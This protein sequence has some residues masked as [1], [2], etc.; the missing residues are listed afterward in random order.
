MSTA[1]PKKTCKYGSEIKSDERRET[2]AAH[3][4]NKYL[5]YFGALKFIL[6]VHS[7]RIDILNYSLKSVQNKKLAMQPTQFFY[8]VIFFFEIDKI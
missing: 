8:V 1:R 3:Q 7:K 5:K 4:G 6:H 2:K